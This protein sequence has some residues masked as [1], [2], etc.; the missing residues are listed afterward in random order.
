MS[1]IVLK[2]FLFEIINPISD[3]EILYHGTFPEL[4]TNDFIKLVS[5]NK[6]HTLFAA[7]SYFGRFYIVD[8]KNNFNSEKNID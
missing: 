1:K 5:F 3:F 2:F 4:S 7:C 6:S 8:L